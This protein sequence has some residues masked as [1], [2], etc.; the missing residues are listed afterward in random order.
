[1]PNDIAKISSGSSPSRICIATI[2]PSPT[3][4]LVV[5]PPRAMRVTSIAMTGSR[6]STT[7]LGWPLACDIAPGA[8][9]HSAPPMA[10]APLDELSWRENSQN[11]AND[12]PAR[13]MVR[14]IAQVTVGPKSNV[15]GA[16]G[17][18]M[19]NIAVFAIRL[20]PSG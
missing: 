7:K 1:M 3:V 10:A 13:P 2:R 4:F 9:P 12:V 5:P 18:E 16:S 6:N 8:K 15:I 17:I 19:P 14:A 20:T 11:H